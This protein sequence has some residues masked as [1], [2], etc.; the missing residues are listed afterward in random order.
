MTSIDEGARRATEADVAVISELAAGAVKELT[1]LRGG[2]IWSRRE[3]R[4][5]PYYEGL[6]RDLRSEDALLVV[7]T[8]DT[9]VIGY[10]ALRIETLHDGSRLGHMTDIYVL[11]EA[12]GVGVGEAMMG[13]L[14]DWATQLD[15]VGVDS[16]ALPGDRATKNFFE[17][18]GL[19]ARSI[20]V[21]R[22]LNPPR[23]S[24]SS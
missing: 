8:I 24:G 19:V 1:V 10:G 23:E 4:T 2:S 17:T 16:L 22:P 21:H 12:R 3:A 5:A 6:A 18:H 7:G 13:L 11:P 14:L 9:A 20:S 15:C